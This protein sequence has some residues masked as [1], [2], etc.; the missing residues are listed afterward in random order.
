VTQPPHQPAIEL[1][2]DYYERDRSYANWRPRGSG[3]YLLIYTTAGGGRFVT[4]TG[5][6]VSRRGDAVLY[7]PGEL[8]D[9]STDPRAGVWKL[10]WAHF[11]PKPAWQMWLSWPV[12]AEG[13]K[14]I[15]LGG[16]EVGRRFSGAMRD[17]VS[18]SRRPIPE[19]MDLAFNSLE[20]ALLWARTTVSRQGWYALDARVRRAMSH[21]IDHFREPFSMSELARHCG[22]SSSRLAHLFKEETGTSPQQYLEVH[23]IQQACS[24]LRI[25]N[26]GIA[27]I[28]SDVGYADPFYFTHRFRR[29][30]GKSPSGYR[31]AM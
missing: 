8:Q 9:Y 3:D 2:G 31:R 21:L 23:R 1:Y 14:T 11:T 17:I 30:T 20:A 16:G 6:H 5:C 15:R 19:A 24:L 25:T 10:L 4:G 7:A 13:V 22:L 18:L 29:H 12:N 26:R 27:E 28:A